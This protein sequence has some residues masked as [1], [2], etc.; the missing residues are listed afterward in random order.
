MFPDD[1]EDDQAVPERLLKWVRVVAYALMAAY[2]GGR[3]IFLQ[4][5]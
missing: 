3:V 2:Y 4:A 1:N 5:E